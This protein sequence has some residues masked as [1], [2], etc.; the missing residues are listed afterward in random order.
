MRSP[1]GSLSARKPCCSAFCSSTCVQP[2]TRAVAC[3]IT[4]GAFTSTSCQMG[5]AIATQSDTRCSSFACAG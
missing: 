2:F 3:S 4:S 5:Y 1:D